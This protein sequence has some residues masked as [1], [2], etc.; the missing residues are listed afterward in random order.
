MNKNTE[1]LT[2]QQ[3]RVRSSVVLQQM[4]FCLHHNFYNGDNN[5]D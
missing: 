4:L 1:G 3:S 2:R 5:A